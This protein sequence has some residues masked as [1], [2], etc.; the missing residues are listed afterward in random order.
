VVGVTGVGGDELLGGVVSA[1]DVATRLAALH[2]RFGEF[3]VR[4][5]T[6]E[7]APDYFED[8][9]GRALSGWRGDAGAFVTD[10]DGRVLLVRHADAP[11]TWGTPGGGHEAGED[12]AETARREVREETG[13]D[14]A[15]TGVHEAV[16]TEIH[17][18]GDRERTFTM[19]TVHF[20]GVVDAAEPALDVGD[21]EILEARWF[22]TAP[23]PDDLQDHCRD[24]VLE[25]LGGLDDG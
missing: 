8:G 13:V 11:E 17:R 1:A 18:E 3:P 10:V 9:V 16:R 22:E 7:N 5:A 4:E 19:L 24:W 25:A 6:R 20:E 21:D 15:L 23:D 12:F 14:P 2:E